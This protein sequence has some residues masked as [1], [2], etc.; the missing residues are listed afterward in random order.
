MK[1]LKIVKNGSWPSKYTNEGIEINIPL[2]NINHNYKKIDVHD[3]SFIHEKNP[4][5]ALAIH[6]SDETNDKIAGLDAEG[7][8]LVKEKFTDINSRTHGG[9]FKVP[10]DNLIIVILNE[11]SITDISSILTEIMNKME[12]NYAKLTAKGGFCL[13]INPIAPKE[14]CGGVVVGG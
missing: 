5:P 11:N 10:K 4:Q 3:I 2:P 13:P 12:E 9:T 6:I 7:V 1:C 14:A 8:L